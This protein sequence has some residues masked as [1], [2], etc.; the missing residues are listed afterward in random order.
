MATAAL[1]LLTLAGLALVAVLIPTL[2]QVRRTARAAELTLQRLDRDLGPLVTAL[3]EMTREVRAATQEGRQMMGRVTTLME[4]SD[5]VLRATNL[6]LAAPRKVGS[7]LL[8]AAA[9]T[10][11]L[12][13]AGEFLVKNLF[14]KGGTDNERG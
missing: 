5:E 1:V 6:V 14:R 8:N 13:T 3:E 2:L 9:L 10:A 4:Y 11:G 12:R 7:Y